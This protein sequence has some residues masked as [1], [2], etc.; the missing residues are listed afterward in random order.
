MGRHMAGTAA[1]EVVVVAGVI[2]FS[3][4]N[5]S[6][7]SL[8]GPIITAGQRYHLAVTQS[9]AT[10]TIYLNGIAEATAS[11]T[12]QATTAALWVG[13]LENGVQRFTDGRLDEFAFY[14][15]ALSSARIATHFSET[16]VPP[17]PRPNSVVSRESVVVLANDGPI[18]RIMSRESVMVLN[19][20]AVINRKLSQLSVQ[21]LISNRRPFVGWG[22]PMR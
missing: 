16:T 9:G 8:S 15:T 12:P 5:G 4:F 11:H 7:S 22:S 18:N 17:T 10:K 3:T 20:E 13:A 21:V 19:N 6:W 14:G 1:W 2:T